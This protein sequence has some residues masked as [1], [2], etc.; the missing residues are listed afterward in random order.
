MASVRKSPLEDR[1]ATFYLRLGIRYPHSLRPLLPSGFSSQGIEMRLF[2]TLVFVLAT[3]ASTFFFAA[4]S[5]ATNLSWNAAGGDNSGGMATLAMDG[6]TWTAGGSVRIGL[7]PADDGRIEVLG[8]ALFNTPT[9]AVGFRGDGDRIKSTAP[10]NIE[11]LKIRM[12]AL[13]AEMAPFLRSFPTK[14]DV[15]ERKSLS[16]DDWVKRFEVAPKSKTEGI[17]RPAW[18][19]IALDV[20]AWKQTEVPEWSYMLHYAKTPISCILW[21][22]KTFEAA[23]ISDGKRVFLVFEGVD[24]EAEVWLN[25]HKLGGHKVYFEPF[26]FDVTDVLSK[27][28]ENTLAVRV[29]DGPVYGEPAANWAPFSNPASEGATVC[30]RPCQVARWLATGRFAYWGRVW[31]LWRRLFGNNRFFGYQ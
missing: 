13:R 14:L 9:I 3:L 25:G 24:W 27:S 29:I 31:N 28:G 17:P 20:S 1:R 7:N 5:R 18:E 2:T 10:E 11:Q 12:A 30:P 21:Y 6:G 15:R 26:K 16:G 4:D 22:R 23:Q 19:N 8:D